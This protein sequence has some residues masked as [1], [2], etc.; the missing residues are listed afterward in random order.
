MKHQERRLQKGPFK[1]YSSYAFDILW[2]NPGARQTRQEHSSRPQGQGEQA[3]ISQLT[4]LNGKLIL[5]G[6]INTGE[7]ECRKKQWYSVSSIYICEKYI[8]K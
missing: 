5:F 6:N 7:F 3:P 2:G 8:W 1:R 4:Q